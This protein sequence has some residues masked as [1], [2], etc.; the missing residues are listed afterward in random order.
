MSKIQDPE[1]VKRVADRKEQEAAETAAGL[2]VAERLTRRAKNKTIDLPL[3]DEDG[4]YIIAMRQPTRRELDELLQYQEAIQK[5]A[6][7]DAANKGMCDMLA[8]LC[9]DS[10]L[11]SEYW[12]RGDYNIDDLV[13]IVQKLFEH[14]ANVIKE[15]GFFR[16][17]RTGT[18]AAPDV[19]VSGEAPP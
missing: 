6:E 18:R 15:A 9:I 2:T 7:H 10:S 3:S 11:N 13:L 4:D 14:F 19:R 12:M 1:L 17:N 5:P 16:S 8:D